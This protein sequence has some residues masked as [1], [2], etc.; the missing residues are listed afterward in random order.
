MEREITAN[1]NHIMNS[2]RQ[3]A[4]ILESERY[5]VDHIAKIMNDIPDRDPS[6]NQVEAIVKNTGEV[7]KTIS[8]Y[9]VS[10]ADLEEAIAIN[11]MAVMKELQIKDEGE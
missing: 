8:S 5:I 1:I 4:K 6:F 11:L 7:T 2:Q 3:M 10:L 9:L